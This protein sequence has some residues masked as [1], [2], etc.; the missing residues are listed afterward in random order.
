MYF[1]VD[2]VGQD[3]IL[4]DE[5]D[6]EKEQAYINYVKRFQLITNTKEIEIYQSKQETNR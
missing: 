3:L 6:R 4:H 5:L 1:H 2:H